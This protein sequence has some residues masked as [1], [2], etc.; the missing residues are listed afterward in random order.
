MSLSGYLLRTW[1]LLLAL[2][3]SGA[4]AA[5]LALDAYPERI[6]L[7]GSLSL[8][9]DPAG[10]LHYTEVLAMG[11]AFR[12]A[13]PADLV[14]G[15]N[16]GVFWLRVSLVHTGA[17]PITRW[18]V[19][20]T[21]KIN[22][23]TL[24]LRSGND[25][26]AMYSGRSVPLAQKPVVATDTVFPVTLAPGENRELLIR[27]VAR[28]AT[29]MSSV[30][31]EPQAYR[32]A[33]GES[34]LLLVAILAGILISGWLALL[35]FFRL[36]Q[37]RYLWLSL[38]LI[39]IA[40]LESAR[41]NFIGLY[42]WPRDMAVPLQMLSL[43]AGL[44][45]FALAKVLSITLDLPHQMSLAETQLRV[46]RWIA[47][48]AACIS[49][50][51]YGL[52]TRLLALV[53]VFV[54]LA[55]LTLPLVLWR[56]GY[57]PAR[58]FSVAFSL[59]LLLETARQLAN[60][61][62]LPWA[63]AMDFSLVG[64]LLSAPF[65]LIGMVEQTRKLSEQLAVAEQLQQAKS[66]FLARVSHELRSP[67][68]TILGF[69]RMLS[70]G[71]ARLTLAEGAAGIEKGAIRLLGLIDEL[72]D[73]SRAAA[74]KLAVS[75]VPT[76]FISWLDE[77]AAGAEVSCEAQGN[78][79]VCL[80][81]GELPQAVLLDGLRLRQVLENLLN[82][83]NRHT[84]R[85]KIQLECNAS[86]KD[87]TAVL[88][89][90]VRD[91]GEGI[92]PE[93]IKV[94]F[95]PFVRGPENGQG[96]RRRRS[97]FGLGLS[98]CREL[99]CQMGSDIAV[100]SDPGK[101]SCFRFILHCPLLAP[102]EVRGIERNAVPFGARPQVSLPGQDDL[103]AAS[104]SPMVLLVEDD[105]E[106][107]AFLRDQL[108]QAGF[109]TGTAR[110]GSAALEQ[111]TNARWDAIITDQMMTE[112][113]GWYLL[114]QIRDSGQFMPVI[115]LSAAL[116]QRPPGFSAGVEFDAI[117]R[118]PA[119]SEDLLTTLWILLLKIGS[120]SPTQ[121]GVTAGRWLE[122]ATLASDGDVSGIEDWLAGL[123][124]RTEDDERLA[125]WVRAA[126]SRLDLSLL[127]HLARKALGRLQVHN[128]CQL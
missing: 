91:D 105:P 4:S 67:L 33:S 116:P 119:L 9:H 100:W 1:A 49:L 94:I 30:L 110:S 82:N 113:D 8:L 7:S 72:L 53:A 120:A 6:D 121:D 21:A 15:F 75:P 89:F 122:L 47:A 17:Q 14:R 38:L 61:G 55:G 43:F 68:N 19:V 90:V 107:L 128:N 31:W 97:G 24:Y 42:L 5:T 111:A 74:G 40:G 36:R 45:L 54:H 35:A 64:Y 104:S 102:D 101:G 93:Q 18:L 11:D 81:S 44:A 56:R 13:Q 115:L 71:S 117:L 66:A 80:R 126:L 99:I 32:F 118:K 65:I 108:G 46:L 27:V 78:R 70:R 112:G 51:D 84:R 10:K 58:W 48:G 96:D 57:A 60:L 98:I 23:V 114:S 12:E 103:P 16:A 86:V 125:S 2:L 29:D 59:G 28:G 124:I 73:E 77:V 76:P 88:E 83:A 127:E 95:E 26:Q 3:C 106:H 20:G 25:W 92:P 63:R 69:A 37:N 52:G 79:F 62:I 41:A 123:D 109:V 22:L 39:A 50:Y 85:G 87:A 34:R